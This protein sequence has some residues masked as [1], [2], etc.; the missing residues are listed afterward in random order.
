MGKK[1]T[2][3][4]FCKICQTYKANEKF[5]GKGHHLHICKACNQ[6]LQLKKQERKLANKK[7]IEA[8]LRPIKK[9]YPKTIQ[10]AA[11]YLE[12]TV[13]AFERY[14]ANLNLD[15]CDF[16]QD[17]EGAIPLFDIDAMITIHQIIKTDMT[18]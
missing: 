8:G 15:P 17:W 6:E 2:Q 3:G 7:A 12:I 14:C 13:V 5:S 1:K 16:S 10:Q 9:A 11:S 18:N 4:H